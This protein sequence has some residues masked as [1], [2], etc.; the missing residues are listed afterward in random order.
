MFKLF[1]SAV[2]PLALLVTSAITQASLIK[3]GSFETLIFDDNTS[4]QGLVHN[5]NLSSFNNKNSAWDVFYALPGWVT[6]SGNGIELQ[7]NIVTSSQHG[8]NHVELDSH[9]HNASNSTMTQSINSL[10][11]GSDYLLT[12]SYKPRTNNNNDNGINV[13]WYDAANDFNI[14][15]LADYSINAKK[16]NHSSW[17]NHS[18]LLT[19]Q[20]ETMDLSF[21]SFG[22]QNGH[23]GLIDNVSLVD[24]NF[25]TS[26]I[27]EPSILALSMFGFALIFI[28]RQ[29]RKTK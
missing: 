26:A 29:T 22:K 8:N 9:P 27:P 28:R 20:S 11:V 15:M 10:T 7:K 6:T 13:F 2:L 19:A 24:A 12:F 14:N 17:Q 5:S 18:I 25:S 3:N 16:K 4:A 23:G 1:V 21:G